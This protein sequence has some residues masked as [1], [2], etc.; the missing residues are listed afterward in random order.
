MAKPLNYG[1]GF[2]PPINGIRPPKI[3]YRY[4]RCKKCGHHFEW[5]LPVCPKCLS[6]EV[7]HDIASHMGQVLW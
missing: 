3:G 1:G 4:Y 7:D 5:L 2:V 6:T